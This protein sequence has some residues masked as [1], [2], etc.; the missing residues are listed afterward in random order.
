[1]TLSTRTLE[2]FKNELENLSRY[3]T[4]QEK[5]AVLAQLDGQKD[6]IKIAKLLGINPKNRFEA[7]AFIFKMRENSISDLIEFNIKCSKCNY[8]DI[9]SLS[10]PDMFFNAPVDE[11]VPIGLYEVVEEIADEEIINNLTITEYNELE[12]KVFKNNLALFD[13][14]VD[15]VCRKCGHKEKTVF[16]LNSII[17]KTTINNLYE[18]YLDIT[19]FTSMT[20]ADVDNMIPFEREVFLGLIQRKE[21]EKAKLNSQT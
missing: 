6:P 19:Y 11:S 18:Q 10:I 9:N 7:I 14:A 1:M 8:M 21:D 3:N 20:K 2:D 17:S 16:N 15:T 5:E 12:Q 4:S 13:P